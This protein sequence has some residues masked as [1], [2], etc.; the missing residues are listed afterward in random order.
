M[1]LLIGLGRSLA[2]I[3]SCARVVLISE[4]CLDLHLVRCGEL[5][6]PQPLIP[7][8]IVLLDYGNVI[9]FPLFYE[10]VWAELGQLV[11]VD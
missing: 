10:G 4:G 8:P 9:I 2:L 5:C 3:V 1:F 6:L 11:V 7:S